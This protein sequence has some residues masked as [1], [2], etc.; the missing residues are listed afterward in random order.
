MPGLAG[1]SR[2]QQKINESLRAAAGGDNDDDNNADDADDDRFASVRVELKR[3]SLFLG[4]EQIAPKKVM[5]NLVA[6]RMV[7]LFLIQDDVCIQFFIPA[8]LE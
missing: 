1:D 6:G 3:F 2:I 4:A 5:A 8:V 7:H